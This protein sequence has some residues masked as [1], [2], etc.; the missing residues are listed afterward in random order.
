MDEPR[1]RLDDWVMPSRGTAIRFGAIGLVLIVATTIVEISL[2]GLDVESWG[3][4]SGSAM[5]LVP[6][7]AGLVNYARYRS[8]RRREW[9]LFAI[10]SWG[11]AFGQVLWI[12]QITIVGDELVSQPG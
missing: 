6:A 12:A 10:G 1:G 7:W 5:V 9:L 4:V 11:W 8:D 3:A 2:H